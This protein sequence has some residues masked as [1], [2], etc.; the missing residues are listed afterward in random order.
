M[1]TI[2][3][4]ETH[5]TIKTEFRKDYIPWDHFFMGVAFMA[6]LRSKDPSTRNGA[7]IVDPKTMHIIS[8]GYNGMPHGRDDVYTWNRDGTP[9]KYDFVIHAEE[10]TILNATQP[11]KDSIMYFYSEKLYLPCKGCMRLIIQSGIKELIING[12]PNENAE[13]YHWEET[14]MMIQIEGIEV[15]VLNDP[16]G[17]FNKFQEESDKA[18]DM[19]KKASE[20]KQTNENIK[21]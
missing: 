18:I 1:N 7:V 13:N 5:T 8:T 14:K 17:M 11:I 6:A 9:N 19:Y 15:G 3:T 12:M 10:N 16:V 21:N 2:D 4:K 20:K